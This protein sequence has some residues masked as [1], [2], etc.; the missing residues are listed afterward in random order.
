VVSSAFAC[1]LCMGEEP[2]FGVLSGGKVFYDKGHF[3][4]M[5]LSTL[6]LGEQVKQGS[7][8]KQKTVNRIFLIYS[9]PLFRERGLYFFG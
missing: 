3:E 5:K 7:I 1:R 8:K 4:Y 2:L 6:R 9:R